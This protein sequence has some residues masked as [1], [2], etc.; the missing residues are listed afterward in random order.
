MGTT[1]S[2]VADFDLG[3]LIIPVACYRRD[4]TSA[5]YA[6]PEYPAFSNPFVVQ[7]LSLACER[8]GFKYGYGLTYTVGSFYIGQGR[9]LNED[10][11]GFWPSYADHIIDDLQQLKVT[12]IEMETSSQLVVG[13]LHGMRMGAV[14]SVISNRVTDRW[15]DEGGELK[16]CLAASE[17]L[18]ILREWDEEGRFADKRGV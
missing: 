3:D 13:Y 10:G 4:G 17:A 5:L 11:S 18:K 8:L 15:G 9:P 1:G 7:A 6:P 12:N 16:S 14:L 2:I